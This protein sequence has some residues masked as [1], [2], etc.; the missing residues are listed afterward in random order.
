MKD[1]GA[2]LANIKSVK[3]EN[4]E[5]EAQKKRWQDLL[6]GFNWSI[7]CILQNLFLV[8]FSVRKR[9]PLQSL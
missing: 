2:D 4:A 1:A 7:C 6:I 3:A 9:S 8:K 5:Y